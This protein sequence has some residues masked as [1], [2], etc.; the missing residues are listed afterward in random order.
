MTSCGWFPLSPDEIRD[1]VEQHKETLP[2]TLAELVTFPIPFRKV[3]VNYVSPEQRTRFW[4]EHLRTFLQPESELSVEQ[5][6]FVAEAIP[7]L[8][9][10]FGSP[11]RADA[12]AKVHAL[13]VRMRQVL[14]R[15]QCG[16]IFAMLGPPE[17]PGG[18]PL[19]A[20]TRLS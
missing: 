3:I 14:T 10:I 1:W 19:P 20:G 16:L 8:P 5:R 2:T 13:E 6:G 17:P 9:E 4:E 18:L 15:Q 11:T 7:M 12:Q